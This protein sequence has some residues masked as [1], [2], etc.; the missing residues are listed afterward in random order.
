VLPSVYRDYYGHSHVQPELMGFALLESMACGTP[1]VCS[2]VGGM[3]EFVRHGRTGF[4]FDEPAEL[5]RCL[6]A[7]ASDPGL[8]DRMGKEARRVVEREFDRRVC[9]DKLVTLYRELIVGRRAEAR[10][11]A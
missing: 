11:A 6:R 3:P 8:A 9:G 5:T 7:L 2:R 4:V 1:A 10:R